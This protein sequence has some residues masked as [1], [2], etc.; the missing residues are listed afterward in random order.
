MIHADTEQPAE[1]CREDKQQHEETGGFVVEQKA[2][3]KEV[4]VADS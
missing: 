2:D 3:G 4:S 1:Q